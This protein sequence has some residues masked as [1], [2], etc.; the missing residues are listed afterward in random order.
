MARARPAPVRLPSNDDMPPAGQPFHEVIAHLGGGGH[1]NF[2]R[3]PG[4][5]IP[6]LEH[7]FGVPAPAAEKPKA[8][9]A[10]RVAM[11]N[12]ENE[13]NR[14][15]PKKPA[16][17][18]GSGAAAPKSKAVLPQPPSQSTMD[19]L[20]MTANGGAPE[21]HHGVYPAPQGWAVPQ[22]PPHHTLS[23]CSLASGKRPPGSSAFEETN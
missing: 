2:Q 4:S 1:A 8:K 9:R 18:K 16:M 11:Q 22:V 12:T 6:G 13:V 15:A 19:I 23:L 21:Q 7:L 17:K 3:P 5:P 20:E 10:E 14:R